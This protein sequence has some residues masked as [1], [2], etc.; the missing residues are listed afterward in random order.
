MPGPGGPAS[1]RF[2]LSQE[3]TS[4]KGPPGTPQS[5]WVGQ[6]GHGGH[7]W[8]SAELEVEEAWHQW[9]YWGGSHR[10]RCVGVRLAPGAVV[11]PAMGM[12]ESS[13]KAMGLIQKAEGWYMSD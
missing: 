4:G 11:G 5:Q 6:W 10:R 13:T 8:A 12:F 3:R 2:L 9:G 7:S 1:Q